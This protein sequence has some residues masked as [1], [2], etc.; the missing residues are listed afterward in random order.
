ML[1]LGST[2]LLLFL[3]LAAAGTGYFVRSRLP[4][5]HRSPDLLILVQL[6][7]NLL[8]TFT[9]IVLGL[10]TTSVKAGFDAAYNTRGTYASELVQLNEC[11]RE[12]ATTSDVRSGGLATCGMNALDRDYSVAVTVSLVSA[13]VRD[14][15]SACSI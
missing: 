8:V 13:P 14:K 3:L 6:T 7:I 9:A 11:L 12:C 10:E 2:A 5:R 15:R 1:D 4:E